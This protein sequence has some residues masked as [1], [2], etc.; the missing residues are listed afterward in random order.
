MKFNDDCTDVV[1]HHFSQNR[2]YTITV[3]SILRYQCAT[4]GMRD[5]AQHEV[6]SKRSFSLWE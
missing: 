1:S 4:Y 2:A 5:G 6:L 3:N